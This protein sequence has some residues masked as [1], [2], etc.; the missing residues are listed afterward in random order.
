MIKSER[1][2]GEGEAERKRSWEVSSA[3]CHR[4]SILSDTKRGWEIWGWE[5][6]A[7]RAL[8]ETLTPPELTGSWDSGQGWGEPQASPWETCSSSELEV[9]TSHG[10]G[11]GGDLGSP[12]GV[13]GSS[14][15][16]DSERS[17]SGSDKG[18]PHVPTSGGGLPA[19]HIT[20]HPGP[21]FADWT[22][23]HHLR[24]QA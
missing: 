19:A 6:Y 15:F 16:R 11:E 21:G 1:F 14:R 10:G 2:G 12:P 3:G 20:S 17:P 13:P 23:A 4:H 18:R 24:V 5:S 7:R 9:R 8:W 22:R